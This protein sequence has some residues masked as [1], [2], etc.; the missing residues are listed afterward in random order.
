[1]DSLELNGSAPSELVVQVLPGC[2]K[3]LAKALRLFPK[4]L[5]V[6]AFGFDQEL[7]I[8]VIAIGGDVRQQRG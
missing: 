7:L 2:A 1:V 8:E 5:A 4:S 6:R 3:W